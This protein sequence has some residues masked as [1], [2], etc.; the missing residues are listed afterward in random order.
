[1]IKVLILA[2]LLTGG[3]WALRQPAGDQVL[4]S[5]VTSVKGRTPGQRNNALLA[6]RRLDGVAIPAGGILSFNRHVGPWT[7]DRGYVIAL[8]SY[9]GELVS[10]WG[11]GVCQTSTTLY[12][13][14][15]LAGL[16]VVERHRHTWAP[17]YIPPGRDAAVAQVAIDLKL[18]NP[19]PWPVRVRTL[20][21]AESIGFEIRGRARGP[22]ASVGAETQ[23]TVPPTEILRTDAQLRSGQRRLLNR[24][25]PGVRVA[26]YRTPLQGR[27]RGVRELVSQDSYPAMNRVVAVGE[28]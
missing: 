16:E 21:R 25:R 9:D 28:R 12:N 23:A 24:G 22:M 11:G 14:A 1:M 7:P 20:Y 5:Y 4:G 3:A 17:K 27:N 8:V 6:A 15:L 2:L 18:R 19:H 26:V 10:D 13:A